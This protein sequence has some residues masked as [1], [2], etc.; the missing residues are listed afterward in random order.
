[1]DV[2]AVAERQADFLESNFK[3]IDTFIGKNYLAQMNSYEVVSLSG[4]EDESETTS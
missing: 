1:M 2:V 3:L 4:N